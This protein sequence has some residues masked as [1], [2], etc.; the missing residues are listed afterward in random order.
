MYPWDTFMEDINDFITLEEICCLLNAGKAVVQRYGKIDK[1]ATIIKHPDNI[2]DGDVLLLNPQEEIGKRRAYRIKYEKNRFH[3]TEVPVIYG[4]EDV[5]GVVRE[6]FRRQ[7]S[8][9][10]T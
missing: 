5:P 4:E 1:P 6:M 10:S 2:V 7:D 8:G 3:L 9:G